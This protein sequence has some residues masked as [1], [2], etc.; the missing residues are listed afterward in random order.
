MAR[1]DLN[2]S[3]TG[4]NTRGDA[5]S[6]KQVETTIIRVMTAKFGLSER[7]VQQLQELSGLR[8]QASDGTRPR[9]AIRRA[10][11][12]AITRMPAMKSKPV[13]AAPTVDDFN[14]LRDDVR[15]IYEAL[16]ALAQVARST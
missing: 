9:E 1:G 4:A 5:T 15:A 14:A 3:Q 2:A 8:G 13:T 11:V 7:N 16:A 10:D 12:G 6:D